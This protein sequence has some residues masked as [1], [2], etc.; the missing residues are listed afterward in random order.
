M[1][2]FILKGMRTISPKTLRNKSAL[3]AVPDVPGW[4]RFWAPG[5]VVKELLGDFYQ[6]LRPGL[7]AGRGR[8]SGY[9]YVYVGIAAKESVRDRLDW[10]INQRHSYSAVKSGFLST[11][12]TSLSS[13]AACDQSDENC[14]DRLIDEMLV[15][16]EALENTGYEN[17]KN[18]EK[19]EK[20]RIDRATAMRLK[21]IE[22]R[23]M[24]R[25]MLP[26]NIQGQPNRILKTG[27]TRH[28]AAARKIGKAAGCRRLGPKS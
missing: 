16:Y 18:M 9:Y 22:G 15:E 28:L 14:T 20:A 11:F 6:S 10:H 19:P 17:R 5:P 12:R 7:T 8:L 25:N 2:F 21:E 24:S 23:E 3:R 1:E 4:Y 26:V 13:L 27:F